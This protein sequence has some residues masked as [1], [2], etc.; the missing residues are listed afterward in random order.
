MCV[1]PC[2]TVTTDVPYRSAGRVGQGGQ[3]G[4]WLV[5]LLAFALLS[6][7]RTLPSGPFPDVVESLPLE[8][9]IIIR[10]RV[11]GNEAL[12]DMFYRLAAPETLKID[13]WTKIRERTALVALGLEST[14]GISAGISGPDTR[15][16]DGVRFHLAAVGNWPRGVM[17][18]IL[19]NEW[20]KNRIRKKSWIGPGNLELSLLG[21][22]RILISSGRTEQILSRLSR[23]ADS[24]SLRRAALLN[25]DS[26][27]ALWIS[28][29]D[30]LMSALPFLGESGSDGLPLIQYVGATLNPH[31]NQYRLRTVIYP[32][33]PDFARILA[34]MIRFGLSTSLGLS[35]SP[36]DQE[37]L[38]RLTVNAQNGEVI[39]TLDSLRIE[40]IEQYL[41]KAL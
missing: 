13:E 30:F 40:D 31:G 34:L 39:I 28:D 5:L 6:S 8:S 17:G 19:G 36:A 11:P 24:A 16:R 14:P 35:S 4:C 21:E 27:F 18:A 38:S 7:C 12:L 9:T 25:D 2:I 26:E 41:E 37:L 29:S 33:E 3:S 15:D 20:K 1:A 23:P 22:N 32:S 10:A